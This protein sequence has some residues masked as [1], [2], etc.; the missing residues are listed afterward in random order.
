MIHKIIMLIKFCALSVLAALL[1]M[2]FGFSL[3]ASFG[4]GLK[5]AGCCKTTVITHGE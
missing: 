3:G 2:S 4:V 1:I 5:F